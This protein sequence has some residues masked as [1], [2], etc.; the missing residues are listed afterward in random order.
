LCIPAALAAV[1]VITGCGPEIYPNPVKFEKAGE[2]KVIGFYAKGPGKWEIIG[3]ETEN[4]GEFQVT[5]ECN[6]TKL[7]EAGE[8]IKSCTFKV[9]DVGAVAGGSTRLKLKYRDLPAG[10]EATIFAKLEL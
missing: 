4:P 9:S 8:G 3:K 7:E 2:T 5:E 6:G 10:G 1:V